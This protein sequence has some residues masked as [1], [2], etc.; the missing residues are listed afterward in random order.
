MNG[1]WLVIGVS[2][3]YMVGLACVSWA[4]RRYANSAKSFTTSGVAYPAICIGFM[5][6]SEFIGTTASVG[7]VICALQTVAISTYARSVCRKVR[8]PTNPDL[9][10]T[11][12][13]PFS[14]MRGSRTGPCLT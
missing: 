2:I 4:A 5:L 8:L 7:T 10:A 9:S 1:D 6:M 12:P 14:A 11:P 13:A 3:A